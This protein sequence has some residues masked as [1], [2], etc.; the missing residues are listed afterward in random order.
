[1]NALYNTNNNVPTIDDDFS[2][3]D[4]LLHSLTYCIRKITLSG[5]WDDA[6]IGVVLE[7][8]EDS[9]LVAM[10]AKLLNIDANT[11]LKPIDTGIDPFIRLM[12][13][14]VRAV[15]S[16]SEL[17]E[18]LYVEF[19]TNRAPQAFPE[20][21]SMIGLQNIDDLKIDGE[22]PLVDSEAP[23]PEEAQ[24]DISRSSISNA[25]GV[26][27]NAANVTNEDVESKVKMAMAAGFF[28]DMPGKTKN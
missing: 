14:G 19:L 18:K 4:D 22:A 27:V 12:K 21:L 26:L 25:G 7:E 20:L 23:T 3:S 24:G 16:S 11:F 1:M 10:P 5:S 6:I 8:K 28:F 9:F 15:A 2:D 17:P 13:S